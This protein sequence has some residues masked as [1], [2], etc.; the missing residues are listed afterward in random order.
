MASMIKK[1]LKFIKQAG[2]DIPWKSK[3]SSGHY[4]WVAIEIGCKGSTYTVWAIHL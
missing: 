4:T 1:D 3:N 2:F